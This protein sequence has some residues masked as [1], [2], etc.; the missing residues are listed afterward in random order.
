MYG[1]CICLH[2]YVCRYMYTYSMYALYLSVC[3]LYAGVSE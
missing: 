3:V 1:V 2:M